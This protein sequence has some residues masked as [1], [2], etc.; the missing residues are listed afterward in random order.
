MIN[1]E[2]VGIGKGNAPNTLAN[3]KPV[4]GSDQAREMQKKSVEA[5]LKNKEKREA[6]A[7]TAKQWK[8]LGK[9]V[10]DDLPPAIDILKLRMLGHMEAGELDEAA[11]IAKTLAEYEQPKLQRVDGTTGTFDANGM[12]DEELDAKLKELNKND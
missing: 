9:E 12:S 5:R 1:K 4:Y 11:E 10:L 3:L 7:L 2:N 8:S 6:M